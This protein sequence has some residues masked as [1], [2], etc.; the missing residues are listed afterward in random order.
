MITAG[1]SPRKM[2][3]SLK[4]RSFGRLNEKPTAGPILKQEQPD[5]SHLRASLVREV[6]T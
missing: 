4:N 1:P 5:T 2:M 6:R 3:L